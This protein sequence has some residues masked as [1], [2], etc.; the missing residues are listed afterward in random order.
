MNRDISISKKQKKVIISNLLTNEWIKT[1]NIY[2]EVIKESIETT[3]D[4]KN[5]LNNIDNPKQK[6]NIVKLFDLLKKINIIIDESKKNDFI[7]SENFDVVYILPTNSCNL[8]CKHCSSGSSPNIKEFL[9]F[10]KVK[11]IID[12]VIL[13]EPKTINFT[14]GEPLLHEDIVKI[15]NYTKENF[16][17]RIN[18]STNGM[19]LNDYLTEKLIDIVDSIDI[20]LDGY[21]EKTCSFIRGKG[22]FETVIKNVKK[23]QKKG[24]N[25]ISLS[26]LNSSTTENDIEKFDKLCE[27]LKVKS[28]VRRFTPIKRGFEYKD[29]IIGEKYEKIEKIQS[30]N[31]LTCRICKPGIRELFIDS[32]G[33]IY[34]CALL[35]EDIFKIDNMFT[36]KSSLKEIMKN[37]P[38]SKVNKKIESLRPYNDICK[39]CNVNTFCWTCL[40]NFLSIKEDKELFDRCCINK[41]KHLTNLIWN[42]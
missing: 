18:L 10:E 21:D 23:I 22:V 12:E 35:T 25:S 28:L 4:I 33:D 29:S 37:F 11:K 30:K 1:S 31:E 6:A 40:G 34:P 41:K 14:G 7:K 27:D 20:S 16:T 15:I 32:K 38:N 17:G 3:K 36:K 24:F 19:L 5:L 8:K 26:M 13:L 2:F 39:D 9:S 42:E